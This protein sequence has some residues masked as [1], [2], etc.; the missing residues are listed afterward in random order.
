[1]VIARCVVVVVVVDGPPR[2]PEAP[3]GCPR[4]PRNVKN[5]ATLKRFCY[6]KVKNDAFLK[7]N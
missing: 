6:L 1:M 4:L 5:D 2:L 7:R 3:R